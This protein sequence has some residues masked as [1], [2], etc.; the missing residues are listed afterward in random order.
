MSDESGGVAVEKH[1]GQKKKS[2]K[3]KA[4]G[5]PRAP[6]TNLI[7]AEFGAN[8]KVAASGYFSFRSDERKAE[9]KE[10]LAALRAK[11]KAAD[12]AKVAKIQAQIARLT[13]KLNAASNSAEVIAKY[14][15]KLKSVWQTISGEAQG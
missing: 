14:G 10:L 7:E 1:G 2:G 5:E 13:A 8:G 12:P 4:S 9:K 6:R 11:S 3:R 15:A